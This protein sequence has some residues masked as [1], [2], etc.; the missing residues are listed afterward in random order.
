MYRS[1]VALHKLTHQPLL[2]PLSTRADRCHPRTRR[3]QAGCCRGARMPPALVAAPS[4]AG[5]RLG[6][7]AAAWRRFHRGPDP[8]GAQSSRTRCPP[9]A[10]PRHGFNALSARPKKALCGAARQRRRRGAGRAGQAGT[11]RKCAHVLSCRRPA[12]EGK[13]QHHRRS[14]GHRRTRRP[15]QP[16]HST[17]AGSRPG[18]RRHAAVVRLQPPRGLRLSVRLSLFT[19]SCSRRTCCTRSAPNARGRV[20]KAQCRRRV[21]HILRSSGRACLV[22]LGALALAPLLTLPVLQL[23]SLESL[24]LLLLVVLVQLGG[25]SGMWWESEARSARLP[26]Q[27][28]VPHEL[29]SLF[30]QGC[31]LKRPPLPQQGRRELPLAAL[32]A[33]L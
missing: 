10:W 18:L 5:R 27:A 19:S 21:M 20:E 24:L 3:S 1:Q 9:A 25:P 22:K 17:Q 23:P 12:P 8:P 6:P 11:G 13:R 14:L 31:L 33:G 30:F 7:R 28:V 29:R 2:Q 15:A 4:R 16:K 32:P 26:G